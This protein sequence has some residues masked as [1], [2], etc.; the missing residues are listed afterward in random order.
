MEA[1]FSPQNSDDYL[2]A[3]RN[4]KT[5]IPQ[6][7]TEEVVMDRRTKFR[8]DVGPNGSLFFTWYDPTLED[9]WKKWVASNA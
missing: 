9:E 8:F 4:E 7:P 2:A 3:L 5:V 1:R 6:K